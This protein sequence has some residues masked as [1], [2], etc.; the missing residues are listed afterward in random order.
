METVPYYHDLNLGLKVDS[1]NSDNAFSVLGEFP[2]LEKKTVM[3]NPAAFVSNRLK[4]EELMVD[5]SGGSTGQGIK[6]FTT[7]RQKF[8]EFAFS[9]HEWE[10]YGWYSTSRVVRMGADGKKKEHENPFSR[11]GDRLLFH[12]II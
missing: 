7:G 8:M 1:I 9:F 12:L 3:E 4:V 11:L 10:K 6:L 5:T 2:F